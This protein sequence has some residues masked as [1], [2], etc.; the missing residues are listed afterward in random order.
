MWLNI[1]K[2]GSTFLKRKIIGQNSNKKTM[3]ILIS[4]KKCVGPCEV[5][6]E[7]MNDNRFVT[8]YIPLTLSHRTILLGGKFRDF[9]FSNNL[10]FP[11]EKEKFFM[12]D[13]AIK[14]FSHN[15]HQTAVQIAFF[16]NS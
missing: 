12:E 6:R 8:Y 15:F 2:E 13:R 3:R 11:Q 9:F 4:V 1:L 5:V 10:S 14:D 16:E 7:V